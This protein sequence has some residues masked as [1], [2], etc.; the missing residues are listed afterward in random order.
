MAKGKSISKT[1][2]WILMGLLFVGLA[3]FGATNL[4]GTI[5]TVGSVGDHPI[6][7]DDYARAL[8]QDINSFQAQTGQPLSFQ[9]AQALG[10]PQQV[11]SRL[12]TTAAF[13]NEAEDLGISA[14]DDTVARELMQITAFQG[15]GGA[16]DRETYRFALDNAGLNESEFEEDLRR[17]TARA[18]LQAAV[19]AGNKMPTTYTETLLGFVGETRDFSW[20]I[21]DPSFLT[22]DLPTATDADL[23]AFHEENIAA[24]TLPES[25][26]ITYAWLTPAMLFDTVEIDE[27]SLRS[28]YDEQTERFNQPERRLV[29]RLV[30]PD[31]E[32]ADAAIARITA[33]ETTFEDEVTSRE[34][35][36]ADVDM[37]DVTRGDLGDAADAIFAAEVDA[38]VGPLPSDFG[39]ALY[40]INGILPAQETSFDDATPILREELAQDRARRVIEAQVTDIDDLLAGG[41]TLEELAAETDMQLG[42]IDWTENSDTD[43]AGYDTFRDAAAAVADG[44]YPEVAELGDGGIFALRLN[45]VKPPQEQ[46]LADVQDQVEQ[47]WISAETETRLLAR[48]TELAAEIGEG[49]T[50]AAVG[51]TADQQTGQTRNGFLPGLPANT[52]TQVFALDAPGTLT[53]PFNG[54]AVVLRLDAIHAPDMTSAE[55]ATI[56]DALASQVSNGISNDL[57][58]A[59]SQDIQ[60]RVGINIDQQALNAVHANFQ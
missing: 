41:A 53:L 42:Q 49:K 33:G 5:R 18:L 26:D 11:L 6:S 47:D 36:L 20:A 14:G 38:V 40:R 1:L 39:P 54:N 59:L 58:Q 9:Q 24:Y 15:P 28:A 21:L 2:V 44:D 37:G 27:A 16:F 19:V 25:R 7:V 34:L 17:E 52:L 30:M 31:S 13:D 46:P 8:Q 50:F 60:S 48:A 45:A 57:F 51:L 12:I 10:L 35:A 29:E 55:N 23:A 22:E 43:I 32:A 56:L 4:S 3:G